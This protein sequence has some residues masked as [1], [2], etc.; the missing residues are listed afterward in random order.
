MSGN[1]TQSAEE[2]E[3]GVCAPNEPGSHS[4]AVERC[5]VLSC[6][7]RAVN[8]RGV[9]SECCRASRVLDQAGKPARF[10]Q[11][12]KRLQDLS[13]FRGSNRTCEAVLVERSRKRKRSTSQPFSPTCRPAQSSGSGSSRSAPLQPSNIRAG[14]ASHRANPVSTLANGSPALVNNGSLFTPH[15]HQQQHQSHQV[16]P[17][18][19][20]HFSGHQSAG[21]QHNQ[22]QHA[23]DQQPSPSS[24]DVYESPKENAA[25]MM[26]RMQYLRSSL[27]SIESTA[28]AMEPREA[29]S[30]ITS[31]LQLISTLSSYLAVASATSTSHIGMPQI[32]GG[33]AAM[34]HAQHANQ[35]TTAAEDL[36]QHAN[37][38]NQH[39]QGSGEWG[40]DREQEQQHVQAQERSPDHPPEGEQQQ[41]ATE[42]DA[43][44]GDESEATEEENESRRVER[45]ENHKHERTSERR[46][47]EA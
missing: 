8:R 1:E 41:K 4:A 7:Q 37:L 38:F 25:V 46:H 14:A 47:T 23:Q 43:H 39:E 35:G 29:T 17:V 13:E 3:L 36:Q 40:A 31:S 10:C 28:S 45:L 19:Q 5:K 12:C 26:A 16:Q 22:Q 20:F 27:Q 11:R 32:G 21:H 24:Q 15:P 9:C 33:N 42:N 34:F 18:Q 44:E 6:G 2:E 30:L